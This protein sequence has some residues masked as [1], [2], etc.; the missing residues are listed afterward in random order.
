M[1]SKNDVENDSTEPV[2]SYVP[3]QSMQPSKDLIEKALKALKV[4]VGESSML[5]EIWGVEDKE[6]NWK[7]GVKALELMLKK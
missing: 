5:S 1:K 4:I 2:D 6:G 7:N 3:I